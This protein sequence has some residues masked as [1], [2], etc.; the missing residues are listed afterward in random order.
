[1]KRQTLTFLL[2][3]VTQFVFGQ[4]IKTDNKKEIYKVLNTFMEC[5][6]E[7][8]SVKF[9]DLFHSEPVVWVGV[10]QKKTYAEELKQNNNAKDNFSA[11]YKSFYR[12]FYD[13]AVEEKFSNIKIVEDGYIAS[14][15]FDYSFWQNGT[16]TNWGKESWGMIK[17]N[18]K[19]KITSVIFSLEEETINSEIKVKKTRQK[20]EE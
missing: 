9:Y 1:M 12:Y 15:T 7:K 5:L 4:T 18:G 8:D 3:I 14:V 2:F 19:W 6:V 16:K 13:K 20:N 17:T 11:N 10:T